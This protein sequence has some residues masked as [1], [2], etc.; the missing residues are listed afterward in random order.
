L[1]NGEGNPALY[2]TEEY[3][4][5]LENRLFLRQQSLKEDIK[6]V[7]DTAVQVLEGQRRIGA[8]VNRLDARVSHVETTVDRAGGPLHP[9]QP[10]LTSLTS[11]HSCL[12]R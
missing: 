5:S 11:N 12:P 2:A 1:I 4:D 10:R 7:G 3:V 9:P 8:K 6:A